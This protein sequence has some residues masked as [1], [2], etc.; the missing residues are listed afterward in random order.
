MLVSYCKVASVRLMPSVYELTQPWK[1][2]VSSARGGLRGE[3]L[4]KAVDADGKWGG[5]RVWAALVLC[6]PWCVKLQLDQARDG[7]SFLWAVASPSSERTFGQQPKGHPGY[8]T[9]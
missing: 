9:Q 1:T 2:V 5:Q 3:G 7:S 6:N 4:H 8:S